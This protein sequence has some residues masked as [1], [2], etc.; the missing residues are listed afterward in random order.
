MFKFQATG[1]QP[2]DVAVF[3]VQNGFQ[4]SGVARSSESDQKLTY[5]DGKETVPLQE[6]KEDMEKYLNNLMYRHRRHHTRNITEAELIPN[7]GESDNRKFICHGN[8]N[9]PVSTVVLS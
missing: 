5:Y 9:Q 3:T 6:C 7:R 8:Q 1:I 4:A 2:A